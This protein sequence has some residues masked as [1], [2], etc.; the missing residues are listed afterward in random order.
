MTTLQM[1][2]LVHVEYFIVV[3]NFDCLVIYLHVVSCILSKYIFVIVSTFSS[4]R[5]NLNVCSVT[6]ETI[7]S[8]I[9]AK[10][11]ILLEFSESTCD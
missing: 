11:H 9:E 2:A 6:I 4:K 8:F 7:I 5:C 10:Q 3:F 1:E